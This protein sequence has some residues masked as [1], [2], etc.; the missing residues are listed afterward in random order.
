M[1]TLFLCRGN[2]GRSV[3]AEALY[4][5]LTQSDNVVSAGTKLSGP[6]QSLASRLPGTKNVI[7][8]MKA[9]GIDVSNYTRKEVTKDMVRNA[10][11][12]I[13]M[14]E[15]ETVPDFV[16]KHPNRI[17]WDTDDP[18]GTDLENHI[19]TKDEI[20]ERIIEFINRQ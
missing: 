2:T 9:E 15:Q 16:K 6:E 20:K 8:A 5:H 1:N 14:A 11:V 18:K 4:N 13:D 19:K 3:F 12:I 17:I 10:D 7:E